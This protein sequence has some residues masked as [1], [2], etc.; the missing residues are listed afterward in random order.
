[1]YDLKTERMNTKIKQMNGTSQNLKFI[2]KQ[3]LPKI[4][5][6]RLWNEKIFENHVSEK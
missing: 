4:Q 5:K 6:P 2:Q 3:V 1:M